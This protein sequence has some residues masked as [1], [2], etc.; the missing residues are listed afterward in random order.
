MH[1]RPYGRGF[2]KE[3]DMYLGQRIA[4]FVVKVLIVTT[5][6]A[7]LMAC[8]SVGSTPLGDEPTAQR[9][10]IPATEVKIYRTVDQIPRPYRE[11]A[12]LEAMGES[13]TTSDS[14]MYA[15]MRKH[16]AALGANGILLDGS[17][18]GNPGPRVSALGLGLPTVR[19]GEAVAIWV[20][21]NG[22]D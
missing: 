22:H 15:G 16:A 11:I 2:S 5:I 19:R 18:E 17:T 12:L 9:S 21:P 10:A 20:E 14:R 3:I 7:V 1:A 13:V 6:V 8:V 4:L